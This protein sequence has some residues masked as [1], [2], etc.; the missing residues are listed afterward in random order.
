MATPI[1]P[2][3]STRPTPSTR[4]WA[5]F[6]LGFRPFFLLAGLSALALL[7]LWLGVWPSGCAGG[8]FDPLIWHGHE[9]LFGY[10]AAVIAGF[11]LTAVQ[12]WTGLPTPRDLP[13]A[14]L[15]LL[16]LAGRAAVALAGLLPGWLV[17]GL[18]L[19]FLPVLAVAIGQRIWAKRQ[20]TITSSWRS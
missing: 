5:P 18:D 8:Y 4:R 2:P 16:W 13:L 10:A 20:N 19:A 11:L 1:T 15:A 6:A 14:L 3:L 17:A 9:L 12:N 7:G